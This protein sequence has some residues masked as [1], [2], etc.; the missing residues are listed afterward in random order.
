LHSGFSGLVDATRV[1]AEMLV[2]IL[3]NGTTALS[4]GQPHPASQTD[5]RGRPRHA[6][7]LAALAREAGADMVQAVDLD[8]GE[9]IR[10][11]I[12]RGMDFDGVA[13]VIAR[14]QCPRWSAAG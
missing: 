14:G 5:A 11:A 9:D 12:E 10:S 6:V 4:G 2:L 13:V 7:D 3:D 8:R 1:G